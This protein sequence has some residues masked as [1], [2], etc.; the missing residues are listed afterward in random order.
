MVTIFPCGSRRFKWVPSGT[1]YFPRLLVWEL[2][3]P[4]LQKFSPIANGY[5]HTENNCTA[6]Q[7]WTK[8]PENA[9]VGGRCI[10]RGFPPNIFAPTPKIPPNPHFGGPFNE[11]PIIE[12]V[13]RKSYVNGATKLI[14]CFYIGRGKY[15][16]G[17]QNFPLGGVW[18]TQRSLVYMGFP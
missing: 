11:K 5:I 3:P 2:G 12:K 17:C 1:G 16:S 13:L 18:G 15:L 14:L 9:Q 8:L 10:L 7:I 4:N 6:R